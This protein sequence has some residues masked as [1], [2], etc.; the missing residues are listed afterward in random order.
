MP[1]GKSRT[2]THK[3]GKRGGARAGAGRPRDQLPAEVIDRLGPPPT[4]ADRL[5]DWNARLL[6]ELLYLQVRG[7]VSVDLAA[8]IRASCGGLD[9]VLPAPRPPDDEDDLDDDGGDGPEIEETDDAGE[10]RVEN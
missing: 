10:L 2:P 6:A 3:K 5:R 4:N 9:R 8:S 1:A 7:L